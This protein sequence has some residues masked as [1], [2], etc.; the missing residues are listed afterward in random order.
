MK[1]IRHSTFETNSSSTH[2]LIVLSKKDYTDFCNDKIALNIHSG[3][4]VPLNK[5]I[6]A[7]EDGTY[8][9]KG[10]EY[11]CLYDL[12]YDGGIIDDTYATQEYLDHYAEVKT[13][14]IDDKVVISIYRGDIW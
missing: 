14:E 13:V 4:I 9:Y 3:E 6:I 1:T 12:I 5:D 8:T 2:A 11:D 10:D 7:H